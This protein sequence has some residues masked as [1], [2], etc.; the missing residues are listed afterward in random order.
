MTPVCFVCR[1]PGRLNFVIV[2]DAPAVF[3]HEEC[4]PLVSSKPGFPATVFSDEER[5][6]IRDYYRPLPRELVMALVLQLHERFRL[7]GSKK[8]FDELPRVLRLEYLR[9][10]FR[11]LR[12][13]HPD[14]VSTSVPEWLVKMA[15]KILERGPR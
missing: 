7:P 6:E 11:A 10:A 9:L 2:D 14:T 8:E 3:C 5:A 15:A 12:A 1:K 13:A 4:E